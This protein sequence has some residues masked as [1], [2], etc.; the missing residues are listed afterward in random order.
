[1]AALSASGFAAE[2]F[3]FLGFPPTRAKDRNLWFES[4][5]TAGRTVVFFES[6]H[7]FRETMKE[8]QEKIGNQ[9]VVVGRELTKAHEELVRSQISDLLSRFT[10]PLG[11]FTVVV[12]CGQ[13]PDSVRRDAPPAASIAE[14]F[15]E[16]T[17]SNG[18]SRRQAAARIAKRH[19][20][21]TNSVYSMVEALKKSG[22]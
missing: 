8:L 12:N 18:L 14:E 17:E 4:L 21:S 7:R 20:L 15:G 3:L 6:P 9:T 22:V 10:T 13:I 11:E 1:M 2:T 5:R 19:G 16:L